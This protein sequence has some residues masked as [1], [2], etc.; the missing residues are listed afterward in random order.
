M[1]GRTYCH[2]VALQT[3]NKVGRSTLSVLKALVPRPRATEVARNQR[4]ETLLGTGELQSKRIKAPPGKKIYVPVRVEPK[5]YFAAERTFL[6][7]VNAFFAA[8][9]RG[10]LID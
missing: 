9:Y 3:A 5:V 1:G 4:L 7:W 10:V 8:F 2:T 6:G